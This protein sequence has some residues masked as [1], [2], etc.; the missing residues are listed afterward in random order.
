[1]PTT[2]GTFTGAV[3]V[4][5]LNVGTA[6]GTATGQVRASG[7]VLALNDP[8]GL[9]TRFV[10]VYNVPTDHF[11]AATLDPAWAWAGAPF[12]GAPSTVSLATF[13]SVAFVYHNALAVNHFAYRAGVDARARATVGPDS[14]VGVRV[15]DDTANNS[16]ELRIQSDSIGRHEIQFIS[17]VGGVVT[18]TIPYTGLVPQWSL[19][20]VIRS[21]TLV[22]AFFSIN[23]PFN[24]RVGFATV[25]WTAVRAGITFGQRGFAN[26]TD[27]AGS[28]D[29]AVIV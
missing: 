21:S 26:N 20:R 11:A 15:D 25:S 13:P 9:F 5:R 19:I 8:A 17:T 3:T 27:R 14:Y 24:S 6:T 28:F 18:T 12:A 29:W 23:T 1:V 10:N 22:Q 16:V 2:G 4:E 7:D